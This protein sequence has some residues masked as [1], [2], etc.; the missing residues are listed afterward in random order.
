ML[1]RED[2]KHGLTWFFLIER[3]LKGIRKHELKMI[4][5]VLSAW[6]QNEE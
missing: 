2:K 5:R 6:G 4:G 1:Q 3:W